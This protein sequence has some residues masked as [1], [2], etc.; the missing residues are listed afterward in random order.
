M[1]IVARATVIFFFIFLLTRGM[2]KRALA[3]MSPFEMIL[4]VTL[5]DIVQQGVTQEDYSLTGAILAAGTFGFWVMAMT[6]GTWRSERLRRMI[7]GVPIV[8]VKDGEPVASALELEQMPI[9]EVLEAARQ[10]GVD[11][12]GS[13][14]LAVLEPSGRISIIKAA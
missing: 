12:L 10:Q 3:E 14:H 8:I 2:K 7:E 11:D 13:I 5:G 4:L 6:W 1:E 9:D